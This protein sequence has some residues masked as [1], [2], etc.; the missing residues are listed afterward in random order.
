MLRHETFWIEDP[1][2]KA[3]FVPG[4]LLF[5]ECGTVHALPEILDE[6]VVFLSADTPRREPIDIIFVNPEDRT[7]ATFMARN[8]SP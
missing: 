1:A 3:E 4:N 7:P 6:P 2:T 8:A 5:F